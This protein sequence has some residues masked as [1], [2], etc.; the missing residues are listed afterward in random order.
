[1][2]DHFLDVARDGDRGPGGVDA[3]KPARVLRRELLERCFDCSVEGFR[4]DLEAIERELLGALTLRSRR[5]GNGEVEGQVR[6]HVAARGSVQAKQITRWGSL[7][8]PPWYAIVES[9]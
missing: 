8:P 9:A 2:H 6:P 4:R 5:A 1:M 3:Q 7:L